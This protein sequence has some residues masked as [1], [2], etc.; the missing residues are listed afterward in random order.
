MVSL[1]RV[2]QWL[3]ADFVEQGV[4]TLYVVL[5]YVLVCLQMRNMARGD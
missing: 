4:E 1:E 3:V 2:D 5:L